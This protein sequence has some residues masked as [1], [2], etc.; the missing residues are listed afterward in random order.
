M[1]EMG[2]ERVEEDTTDVGGSWKSVGGK[3][4]PLESPRI[5]SSQA[6]VLEDTQTLK[7]YDVFINSWELNVSI[8]EIIAGI[9]LEI[10]DVASFAAL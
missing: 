6:V 3:F 8:E 1:L 4:I 5:G 10:L 2:M 9:F 7:F